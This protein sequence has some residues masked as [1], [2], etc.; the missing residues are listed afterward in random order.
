MSYLKR[1]QRLYY[2]YK[3]VKNGLNQLWRKN[4][5][6]IVSI[7][8][9]CILFITG[10]VLITKFLLNC[11]CWKSSRDISHDWYTAGSSDFSLMEAIFAYVKTKLW[12]SKWN[13]IRL[14]NNY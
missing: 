5:K 10:F 11:I 3:E 1:L 8:Y 6:K 7:L 12:N 4:R 14:V 9:A 13:L 2:I